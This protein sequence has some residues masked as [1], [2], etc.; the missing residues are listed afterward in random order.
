MWEAEC[1]EFGGSWIPAPGGPHR[2]QP[3]PGRARY[4]QPGAALSYWADEAEGPGQSSHTPGA[5]VGCGVKGKSKASP[6]ALQ[7][8]GVGWGEAQSGG[9]AVTAVDHPGQ[10]GHRP[11]CMGLGV[12]GQ[13]CGHKRKPMGPRAP[14]QEGTGGSTVTL[15]TVHC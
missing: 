5:P 1:A 9:P 2:N 8:P 7:L 12:T 15:L 6:R 4:S 11:L 10:R 14:G 13:V 3:G